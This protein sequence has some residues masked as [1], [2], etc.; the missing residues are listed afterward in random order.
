MGIGLS[1]NREA[2]YKPLDTDIQVT[3]NCALSEYLALNMLNSVES[4]DLTPFNESSD[5]DY[6][7]DAFMEALYQNPLILAIEHASV[8]RDDRHLY[9]SYEDSPEERADKQQEIRDEVARVAGE[10]ITDEMLPLEKEI[11]IN[12]YLC[13]TAEYDGAALENAKMYDFMSVDEEFGDS[14]TPYGVLINKMG[15]GISYSGAF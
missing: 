8:S 15:A 11:A 2:V 10:I 14:F 4:I 3:A 1:E 7:E 5:Q 12:R 13:D 6:L 9:L